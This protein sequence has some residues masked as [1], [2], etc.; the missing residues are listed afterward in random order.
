MSQS[1]GAILKE[2]RRI[3]G[4]TLIELADK[5]DV[6]QADLALVELGLKELTPRQRQR[7]ETFIRHQRII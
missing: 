6:S 4:V 3:R 5:T 2:K 1:F 7:L